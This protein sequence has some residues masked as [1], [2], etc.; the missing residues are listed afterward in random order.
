M[1]SLRFGK[2]A[3]TVRRAPLVMGVLNVT[4]DSFSDGGRFLSHRA[5]IEQAHRMAAD[6]ADIIDIGGESTRPGSEPVSATEELARVLP[7]IEVLVRGGDGHARLPLPISIDTHKPEVAEAALVTGCS[8]VNDVTA[9]RDSRMADVL[10]AHPSAA[11][12]LMHMLGEPRTMQEDPQYAEVVGEVTSEL[13]MRAASLEATGIARERIVLDPGIGFGKKL[14]HNLELLRHIDAFKEL[15]YPVLVGGS[16][17]SFLG[18]L[19]GSPSGKGA[20]APPESRLYGSLAVAAWCY[21]HRVDMIR[22]HDV[23]ETVELFRVLDAIEDP[24]PFRPKG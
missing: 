10:R 7:V 4:P 2:Y 24:A 23:R 11:I 3:L 13:A 6:G 19:L 9:A 1:T 8:L 20:G 5:A 22:V 15:G 17:K 18:T 21:A 12:I 14:H 16:R